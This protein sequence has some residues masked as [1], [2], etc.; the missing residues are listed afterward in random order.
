MSEAREVPGGGCS[1]SAYDVVDGGTLT[2]A[3]DTP[4]VILAV[5]LTHP[6]PGPLY[7]DAM[8]TAS[9][10]PAGAD[11]AAAVLTGR[12][13]C[14]SSGCPVTG[15][16]IESPAEGVV[17]RDPGLPDAV[18]SALYSTVF[19]RLPAGTYRVEVLGA[20]VNADLVFR[21]L[22]VFSGGTL[23]GADRPGAP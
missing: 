14:L 8:V 13:T 19:P 20:G 10:A 9:L 4:V 21:H 3:G 12:V 15:T 1:A 23:A 16:L 6:C 18:G 11:G 7:V 2:L 17:V 22:Q 5:V